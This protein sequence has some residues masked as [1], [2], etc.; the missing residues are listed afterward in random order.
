M[1]YKKVLA[2]DLVF[3]LRS[4]DMPHSADLVLGMVRYIGRLEEYIKS[5]NESVVA[6]NETTD[7]T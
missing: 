7:V 1:K 2:Q 5:K 4:L 3:K 6:R